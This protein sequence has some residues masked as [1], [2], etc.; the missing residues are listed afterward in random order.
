[1]CED[2]F[3]TTDTLMISCAKVKLKFPEI[4]I[5]PYMVESVQ[6]AHHIVYKNVVWGH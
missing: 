5:T 1:M 4:H 6:F 3:Q 2:P